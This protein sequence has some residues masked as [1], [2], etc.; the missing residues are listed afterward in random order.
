MVTKKRGVQVS[1]IV[2][3]LS[4]VV[5]KQ[6]VSSQRIHIF[7]KCS[8]GPDGTY[9]RNQHGYAA[10]NCLDRNFY[11]HLF[12]W[13]IIFGSWKSGCTQETQGHRVR[14]RGI[15]E[16]FRECPS[17]HIDKPGTEGLFYTPLPGTS[18]GGPIFS[19]ELGL[20][21]LHRRG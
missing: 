2:C 12:L 14:R 18:G 17:K 16:Q 5:N 10:M 15:L 7:S 8:L 9:Y 13:W 4:P 21:F 6:I 1:Q 19:G 3:L 11:L 20:A